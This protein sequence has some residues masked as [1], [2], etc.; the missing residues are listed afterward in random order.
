MTDIAKIIESGN[1]AMLRK[2]P[3]L[4]ALATEKTITTQYFFYFLISVIEV[5][6]SESHSSSTSGCPWK[7]RNCPFASELW[8]RPKSICRCPPFIFRMM[9]SFFTVE[10]PPHCHSS[11]FPDHH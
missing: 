4:Q 8:C 1:I 9:S 10:L 6:S 3:N 2:Q 11:Q 7:G 5:F